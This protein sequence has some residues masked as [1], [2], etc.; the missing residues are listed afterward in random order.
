M[1]L[2]LF[3]LALSG[4]LLLPAVAQADTFNFSS[5]GSGGGFSGSG[6]LTAT[7]NGN[8]SFSITGITGTGVT[9]LIGVNDFFGNDNLLFPNASRLVDVNGFAF[10]AALGGDLFSVNIFSTLTGYEAV[11][12]DSDGNFDDTP[13]TFTVSKGTAL[14]PEPASLVMMGSGLM[15]MAAAGYRKARSN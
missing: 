5:V 4:M 10:T 8:G 15:A 6:V 13:V 2:N 14:T 3:S 7:D 11:T 1:R 9:G 12:M